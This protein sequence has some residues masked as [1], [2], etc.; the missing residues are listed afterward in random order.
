M[1]IITANNQ[2]TIIRISKLDWK[3]IGIKT[4]WIKSAAAGYIA[5][6]EYL[7]RVQLIGFQLSKNGSHVQLLHPNGLS[8]TL[9]TNNWEK[10]WH[11]QKQDLRRICYDFNGN[12]HALDFIWT[13]PFK[14][15]EGFDVNS[16]TK[17][18]RESQRLKAVG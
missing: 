18:E 4:G 13:T 16:F 6:D 7:R 5:C 9:S 1:K 8:T 17:R 10:N 3:S 11:K 12:F 2:K 14:I 15:P